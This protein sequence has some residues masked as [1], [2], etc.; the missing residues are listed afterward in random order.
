M[1]SIPTV[2]ARPSTGFAD[3]LTKFLDDQQQVRDEAI[4]AYLR[5]AEH[6]VCVDGGLVLL[7]TTDRDAVLD[8]RVAD[9]AKPPRPRD[10]LSQLV[11]HPARAPAGFA[12]GKQPVGRPA[13]LIARLAEPSPP[14]APR[15]DEVPAAA[16]PLLESLVARKKHR[17]AVRVRSL[18]SVPGQVRA[19]PTGEYTHGASVVRRAFRDAHRPNRAAQTRACS[20]M[21]VAERLS[22]LLDGVDRMNQAV[23]RIRRDEAH[24]LTAHRLFR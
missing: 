20:A 18:S 7:D 14:D 3:K 5:G 4:A 13:A 17:P 9:R 23:E 6:F 12:D 21:E 11:S 22:G 1:L 16:R 19:R 8:A 10:R 24:V 15:R 2:R